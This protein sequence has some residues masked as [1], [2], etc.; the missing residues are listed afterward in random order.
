M[1]SIICA[2]NLEKVHQYINGRL[3]D[4]TLCKYHSSKLQL[5]NGRLPIELPTF[6]II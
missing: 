6:G 4:R 5:V 2:I 1:H 3:A